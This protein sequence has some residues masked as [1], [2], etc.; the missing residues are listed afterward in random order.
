MNMR[1][2]RCALVF[3]LLLGAGRCFAADLAQTCEA[4]DEVV[5][6]VV[7]LPRVEALLKPGQTLRILAIGSVTMFGPETSLSP[8]TVTSQSLAASPGPITTSSKA[9]KLEASENAFPRVMGRTLMELVPGAKVQV[10]VRGGRGL[11]AA[12]SLAIMRKELAADGPFQLVIWQTGTVEA[13]RNSPPGDFAQV[14]LEGAEAVS[15]ANA[16]L[17]MIDSQYSR[18]LQTNSNIEPYQ[19]A[20]QQAAS[21]NG[22][23]LFHRFDLMHYWVNEGRIDLERTPKSERKQVIETMH[24]CIGMHLARAI[25]AGARS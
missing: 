24:A 4:P 7:S 2:A 14:L 10:V 21:M 3:V 17:L 22:V 15:E 25:L 16:N 20:L 12:D 23:G 11:S 8:G 5:G 9:L 19:Q 13:V 18:F 1:L 6:A